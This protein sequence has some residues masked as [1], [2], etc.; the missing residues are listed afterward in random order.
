MP[1]PRFEVLSGA[2]NGVNLVFTASVP[3]GPGTTAVYLNGQLLNPSLPMPAWLETSPAAG[4][5]T[6]DPLCHIPRPGDVVQMFFLDTSPRAVEEEVT[7]LQGRIVVE[8]EVLGLLLE[9]NALS[10]AVV[11]TE[12]VVAGMILDDDLLLGMLQE[13]AQLQGQLFEEC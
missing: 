2:I 3:Y 13:E 11:D 6:F 1:S 8:A 12:S 4:T 5:V 7:P 9:E 10:G